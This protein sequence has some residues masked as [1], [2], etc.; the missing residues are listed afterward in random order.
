MA[1]RQGAADGEDLWG[2]WGRDDGAAL[3]EGL[4]A[5]DQVGGPVG[6]VAQGALLDLGA[7]AIGLAQQDGGR[8][9]AVGDSLDVH[10]H[11]VPQTPWLY[12]SKLR[13]YMATI[14]VAGQERSW[15]F[16]NLQIFKE[17]SSD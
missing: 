2:G 3:E 17:R 15:N 12:K 5:L 16:N 14:P 7:L 10:G 13:I 4:E 1:V 11:M 9:V 8:R 6:K